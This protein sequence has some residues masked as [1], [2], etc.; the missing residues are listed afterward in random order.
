MAGLILAYSVAVMPGLADTSDRTFVDAFQQIDH[1]LDSTILFW[2][3]IFVGSMALIALSIVL[4]HKLRMKSTR[5]WLITAAMLY[6][7]TIAITGLGIDPLENNIGKAG[8]PTDT[9]DL[10]KVRAD[11]DED[12]WALLNSIRLITNT[13]AFACLAWSLV[14]FVRSTSKG[15]D[16]ES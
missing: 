12:R 3:V 13:G 11:F 1:A 16:E 7:A 4:A 8:N 2:I 6:A 15:T 10:S 14:L 9:L 5:T